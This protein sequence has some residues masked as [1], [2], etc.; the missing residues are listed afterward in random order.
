MFNLMNGLKIKQIENIVEK[1][2]YEVLGQA[3][4]DR[5]FGLRLRKIMEE[6]R[7]T[8]EAIEDYK[9]AKRKGKLIKI[10]SLRDLE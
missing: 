3:S 2:I 9:E 6:I 7:D 4:K 8:D 1:K 10:N 5:N